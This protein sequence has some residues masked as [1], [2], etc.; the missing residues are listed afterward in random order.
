MPA[1][2]RP[3]AEAGNDSFPLSV[4]MVLIVK[5]IANHNLTELFVACQ[6]LIE[7]FELAQR[8]RAAK[9]ILCWPSSYAERTGFARI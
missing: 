6:Q 5:P 7:W 4:G 8:G 3:P 1:P 9:A 2:L